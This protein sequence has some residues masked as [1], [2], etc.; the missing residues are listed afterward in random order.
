MTISNDMSISTLSALDP[1][2]F[3][4][5]ATGYRST[6]SMAEAAKSNVDHQIIKALRQA[7]A[8][9]A[10]D[11]ATSQLMKL[12]ENFH[13][14]QVE[15]GLITGALDGFA[16][17][18]AAP[19]QRL[20]NALTEAQ[21]V[22]FSI[23]TG[24]GAVTYPASG[25]DEETGEAFPGGTVTGDTG[26]FSVVHHG[27]IA[28]AESQGQAGKANPHRAKAM[29]IAD[30]IAYAIREA[31]DIDARYSAA[32]SKLQ[33]PNR[34]NVTTKLWAD[35]A[36]DTQAVEAAA[37]EYLA[38]QIP[39][40]KSA[41]ERHAW[42]AGLTDEQRTE[43]KE[44]FPDVIG[45]LDGVPS[46]DRNEVNRANLPLL[47]AQL[48]GKHDGASQD[49]LA[50]LQGIQNKLDAGSQPPMYLLGVGLEG[51]GRAIVSYG[52]PDTARN[53]SAYVPGLGTKLDGDFADGDVKRAFDTAK[54][55]G[56]LDP[57]TAS[58]V[59][60]GYDAPQSADVMS[61]GD[62]ERGAPAYDSFMSGI[63][64][65]NDNPDPH[66]TA[67][68]HSYGSRLVGAATQVPGGIPGADDI[69]LVGSPG[70][71]VDR[72]E[73][74]GVGKNHVW[75]G[76][77]ANDVVTHLP[78][79]KE[80]EYGL[81]GA[82]AGPLGITIGD[83]IADPH[84]DQL[85]FG[86][87]PASKAFGANRFSTMPGPGL[88]HDSLTSPDVSAHSHYFSPDKD[89]ISSQNIAAIVSGHTEKVVRTAPR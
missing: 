9:E 17:E 6:K 43:Y 71:G 28:V 70:T 33:A 37:K 22:G 85:W 15:C 23:D 60:L 40:D 73:D 55:A 36:S 76:A 53:V 4:A 5:A 19:V 54:G 86:T 7:N 27:G 82:P 29:E 10:A 16:A 32:L 48:E 87:D 21:A 89:R 26:F 31:S 1:A 84:S 41:A 83:K 34:L 88:F 77:A 61:A 42:W 12:S 59:W 65:T 14:V 80:A 8:G 69:I 74:L 20:K 72:A 3:T 47:I 68:G 13:Y 62:A 58:I 39:S 11:A 57:S 51:N 24:T 18:I 44:A 67:I 49:K 25:L 56:K 2:D 38:K 45:N 50:G 30:S 78:S 79:H 64:A 75:V 46:A 81:I 52:N 35:A 63:S 66:I